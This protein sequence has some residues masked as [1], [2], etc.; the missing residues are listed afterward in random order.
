M[1]PRYKDSSLA[2]QTHRERFFLLSILSTLDWDLGGGEGP[3]RAPRSVELSHVHDDCDPRKTNCSE[4][5]PANMRY[6]A[7]ILAP[8]Y[9]EHWI[10]PSPTPPLAKDGCRVISAVRFGFHSCAAGICQPALTAC[11]PFYLAPVAQGLSMV[12]QSGR[13][14][15]TENMSKQTPEKPN[16]ADDDIVSTLH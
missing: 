7:C 5:S 3:G 11:T 16:L 10:I 8:S 1:H 9:R 13:T 15:T 2:R 4:K 6:M 14:R 12:N